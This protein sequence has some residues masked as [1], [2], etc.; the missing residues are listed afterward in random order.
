MGAVFNGAART[1]INHLKVYAV[2][3][4]TA[5][6]NGAAAE[7]FVVRSVVLIAVAREGAAC[8]RSI[9]ERCE[10]VLVSGGNVT[11]HAADA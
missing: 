9:T 8:D 11:A 6:D 5:R 2:C 7:S 10:V 4:L 3:A 1:A